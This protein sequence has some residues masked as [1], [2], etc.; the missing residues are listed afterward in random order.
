ML[1]VL[2]LPKV[3]DQIRV[4]PFLVLVLDHE[5]GHHGSS[6]EVELA[7]DFVEHVVDLPL[8]VEL[9]G[10]RA[11]DRAHF[12][13]ELAPLPGCRTRT[14]RTFSLDSRAGQTYV[15]LAQ[16]EVGAHH[17]EADQTLAQPQE[18]FRVQVGHAQNQL[19]VVD[20][21][22]EALPEDVVK[23]QNQFAGL[24]LLEQKN[25][26]RVPVESE[27]NRH[28]VVVEKGEFLEKARVGQELQL[29]AQGR[30]LVEQEIAAARDR[31][32]AHRVAVAERLVESEQSLQGLEVER[33][34]PEELAEAVE[35]DQLV[36]SE[37]V[38]FG[39]GRQFEAQMGKTEIDFE[40]NWSGLLG[41]VVPLVQ[42]EAQF[43]KVH[44]EYRNP[45]GKVRV[46]FWDYRHLSRS[47]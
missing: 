32:L 27:P 18:A 40:V 36:E 2:V 3:L 30:D 21:I 37:K 29:P 16:L 45:L 8:R 4:F 38:Q 47:G 20:V 25:R 35:L 41:H 17:R 34:Q 19:C 1:V 5:L 43:E 9:L 11:L 24:Q 44:F 46:D 6:L 42:T 33:E 39:L 13:L 15:R 26:G 7:V 22:F 23:V 12:S 28:E 14:C 10:L 31:V